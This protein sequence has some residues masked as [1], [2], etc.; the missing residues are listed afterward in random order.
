[1]KGYVSK[2][3]SLV[4]ASVLCAHVSAATFFFHTDHLGTPQLLTDAG[5]QIVWQGEYDPFG[6]VTEAAST[7]KQNLRF[8]GQY[9]DDETELHYNYFRSYDPGIGRY[10]KSDPIGLG[11]GLNT[12]AYANQ[13]PVNTIDQYGLA[14]W[15]WPW[16]TLKNK[17]EKRGEYIQDVFNTTQAGLS[18]TDCY[19][20]G[21]DCYSCCNAFIGHLR[22]GVTSLGICESICLIGEIKAPSC[23]DFSCRNEV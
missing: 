6:E 8:P 21:G 15:K 17:F 23:K 7:I 11:G 2:V 1:M 22:Y 12:F 4:L 5:R 10:V 18:F 14:G 20:S 3:V 19:C 13:D 16:Q 9:F